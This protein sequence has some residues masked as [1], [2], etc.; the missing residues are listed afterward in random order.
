MYVSFEWNQNKSQ[1]NLVKHHISFDL[2]QH[3]F[4]DPNQLA[5]IERIE[6][7]E[8]RWQTIGMVDG[9]LILL[10]VHTTHE[11]DADGDSI[12]IIRIISARKA[13]AKERREYEAQKFG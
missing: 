11:I 13:D 9:C 10:V 7:G 4:S 3:V 1:S 2:A 12:E 6:G 5:V 8:Q